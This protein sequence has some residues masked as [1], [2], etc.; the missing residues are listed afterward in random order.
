MILA[1]K[2]TIDLRTKINIECCR[3]PILTM[4]WLLS[5]CRQKLQKVSPTI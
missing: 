4:G 3:F 2:F 1:A 5:A